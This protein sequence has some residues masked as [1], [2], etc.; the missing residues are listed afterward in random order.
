MAKANLA[1]IHALL[2][3]GRDKPLGAAESGAAGG[4]LKTVS[5]PD[6]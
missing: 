5:K 4:D 1:G 3:P 2:R 6:E